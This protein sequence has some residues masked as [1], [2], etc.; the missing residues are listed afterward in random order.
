[1]YCDKDMHRNLAKHS[2]RNMEFIFK[3]QGKFSRRAD[4]LNQTEVNKMLTDTFP[5]ILILNRILNLNYF[6]SHLK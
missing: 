3:G 1:M 4:H 2:G 5:V 6:C